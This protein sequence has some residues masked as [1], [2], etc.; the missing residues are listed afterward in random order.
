LH[1]PCSPDGWKREGR[2]EGCKERARG[3]E[4]FFKIPHLTVEARMDVKSSIVRKSDKVVF[5][6]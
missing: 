6:R 5:L 1:H 4:N 2:E 3:E